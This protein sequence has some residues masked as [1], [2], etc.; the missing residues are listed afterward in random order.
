M[1]HIY[2]PLSLPCLVVKFVFF[3]ANAYEVFYY[4]SFET[5]IYDPFSIP[6]MAVIFIFY[7][8]PIKFLL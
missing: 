4:D 2:E 6:C 8:C 7:K 1:F 3:F 5:Y